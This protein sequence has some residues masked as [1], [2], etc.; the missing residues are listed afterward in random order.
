[1]YFGPTMGNAGMNANDYRIIGGLYQGAYD[2]ASWLEFYLKHLQL[3]RTT[4]DE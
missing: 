1:M 2:L 3:I 4:A